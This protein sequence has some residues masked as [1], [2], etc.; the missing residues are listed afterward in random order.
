MQVTQNAVRHA[1][2]TFGSPS[3]GFL[4]SLLICTNRYFI[5]SS[6]AEDEALPLAWEGSRIDSQGPGAPV[7]DQWE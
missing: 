5:P 1:L 3:A 6:S 4:H 7:G 2:Q